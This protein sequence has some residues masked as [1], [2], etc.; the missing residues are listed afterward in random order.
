M[1]TDRFNNLTAKT[2]NKLEFGTII[3]KYLCSDSSTAFSAQPYKISY[4]I[5][6]IL[7]VYLNQTYSKKPE[8]CSSC[9]D[10]VTSITSGSKVHFKLLASLSLKNTA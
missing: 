6:I 1:D 4:S 5:L 2:I 3:G 8:T 10:L 9:P 7:Y